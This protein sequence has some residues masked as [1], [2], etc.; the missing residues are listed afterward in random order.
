MIDWDW[1]EERLV[2][3]ARRRGGGKV[4]L[5]AGWDKAQHSARTSDT[6]LDQDHI[7]AA[8]PRAL[9]SYESDAIAI[10][11]WSTVSDKHDLVVIVRLS[12]SVG[13]GDVTG[14]N[15]TD[16]RNYTLD[17]LAWADSIG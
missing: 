13:P 17:R 4:G 12:Q 7:L 6:R 1:M 5:G 9:V 10:P 2:R 11:I 14:P 15:D 8:I 3:E 16:T